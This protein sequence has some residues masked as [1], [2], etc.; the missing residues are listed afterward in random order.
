MQHWYLPIM[1]NYLQIWDFHKNSQF[2]QLREYGIYRLMYHIICI[3][4]DVLE[5]TSIGCHLDKPQGFPVAP[6]TNMV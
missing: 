4:W 3:F 1:K 2:T 6:F 5:N